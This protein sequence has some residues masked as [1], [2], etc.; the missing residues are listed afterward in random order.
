[1]YKAVG[2][3]GLYG[4]AIGVICVRQY[5]PVMNLSCSISH[6][7]IHFGQ[8]RP[9]RLAFK[10]RYFCDL[11]QASRKVTVRLKTSFSGLLSFSSSTK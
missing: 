9:L 1:V 3:E 10:K 8:I 7:R 6:N 5:F 4:A 2:R 11:A